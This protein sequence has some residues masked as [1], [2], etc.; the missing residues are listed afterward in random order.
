MS[1]P[2]NR[3]VISTHWGHLKGTNDLNSGFENADRLLEQKRTGSQFHYTVP[4]TLES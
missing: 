4:L 1:A 3:Q 2:A